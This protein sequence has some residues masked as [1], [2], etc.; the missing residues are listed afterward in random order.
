MIK[1]SLENLIFGTSSIIEA[2]LSCETFYIEH[3][4]LARVLIRQHAS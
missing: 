4:L 2:S 3:L 1:L